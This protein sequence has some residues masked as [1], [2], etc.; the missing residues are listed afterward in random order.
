MLSYRKYIYQYKI[1]SQKTTLLSAMVL[2]YLLRLVY[3]QIWIAV[4]P[5]AGLTQYFNCC[6]ASARQ[7]TILDMFNHST[8]SFAPI[9]VLSR[10]RSRVC[11]SIFRAKSRASSQF[12]NVGERMFEWIRTAHAGFLPC[13]HINFTIFNQIAMQTIENFKKNS[14]KYGSLSFYWYTSRRW[15]F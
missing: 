5:W 9:Y 15:T 3:V 7:H 4:G 13:A 2:L 8:Q 1:W 14:G 11:L 12:L 6:L 10:S